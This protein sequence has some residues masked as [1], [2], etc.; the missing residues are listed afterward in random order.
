MKKIQIDNELAK[1]KVLKRRDDKFHAITVDQREF[2]CF[3][4]N[5]NV[6]QLTNVFNVIDKPLSEHDRRVNNHI[7]WMEIKPLLLHWIV[8]IL[9]FIN[10]IIFLW[11]TK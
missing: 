6:S 7:A 8:P 5:S 11:T 4:G 9:I 3:D 1:I 2:Q 10:F